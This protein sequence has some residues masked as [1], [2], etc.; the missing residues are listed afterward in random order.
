MI[1][2][3]AP[4][5]VILDALA[6]AGAF[7]GRSAGALLATLTALAA[8]LPSKSASGAVT[9]WQVAKARGC[10]ERAARTNLAL[11]ER[12][13]LITWTRGFIRDGRGHPG[14][15][16][17][18]KK[19]LVELLPAARKAG[20][21]RD[22]AHRHATRRRVEETTRTRTLLN[23][24]KM[25]RWRRTGTTVD[26]ARKAPRLA[27]F[28]AAP[29]PILGEGTRPPVVVPGTPHTYTDGSL[30]NKPRS[31]GSR[32]AALAA[33]IARRAGSEPPC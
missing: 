20:D 8:V 17:V 21:A 9:V 4:L 6:R 28:N 14:L 24:S 3:G 16:R 1:R 31:R 13:G 30:V 27:A 23:R 25:S 12:A 2:A 22:A 7:R 29:P 33:A 5:G 32:A 10:S 19:R 15:I 11:L 26:K 18:N